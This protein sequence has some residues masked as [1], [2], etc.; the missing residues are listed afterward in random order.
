MK[1]SVLVVTYNDEK[2]LAECL[3]SLQ[4][5][6]ELIVIDLGST[7]NSIEIAQHKGAIIYRQA[8]VPA[9]ELI[10]PE[11]V[12]LAHNNWILRI[13]P[14]EIVPDA[15]VD[16][17]LRLEINDDYGM[18]TIPLQYY[19]LKRK[20]DTTAWGGIRYATR[21]SH[22]ERT[23]MEKGVHSKHLCKDG[24]ATY[25][26][27]FSGTNAITH[28]WIDSFSQLFSK[29]KR[30]LKL[31]GESRFK[32]S[33]RFTW[34]QLIKQTLVHFRFSFIQKSGWRGGWLGWFLSFFYAQYEARA[35]LA[36]RKYQ[37]SKMRAEH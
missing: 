31:E 28:Y 33:K 15:L 3:D 2:H 29:H 23:I 6:D 1:L 26:I 4:R 9:I 34:W 18:V 24:Y 25:Q 37:N 19:F 14:D 20:L 5:F 13:D 8:W 27:D 7:D 30:Y 32:N 22:N 10:L 12:T 17:L 35:W 16:E 11:L 21:I 36:L